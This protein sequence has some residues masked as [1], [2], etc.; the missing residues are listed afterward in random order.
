[1]LGSPRVRASGMN[2]KRKAKILSDNEGATT[3]RAETTTRPVFNE[4][5]EDYVD[6]R[7]DSTSTVSSSTWISKKK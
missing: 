1:M 3:D 7:D 6:L 2:R 4:A 5:L